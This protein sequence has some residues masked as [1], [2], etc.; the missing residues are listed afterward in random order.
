MVIKNM[1]NNYNKVFYQLFTYEK[2]QM[3]KCLNAISTQS[4]I[5]K[6]IFNG[7]NYWNLE[8]VVKLRLQYSLHKLRLI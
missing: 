5:G 2:K 7:E 1:K 8:W 6:K 3:K 4:H